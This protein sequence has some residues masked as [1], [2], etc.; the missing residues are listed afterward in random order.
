[1]NIKIPKRRCV[2][3]YKSY[4]K[5]SL[6]R[7]VKSPDGTVFYDEKGSHDGRGAYIC[8]NGQCLARV[9][10]TGALGRTLKCEIPEEIFELLERQAKENE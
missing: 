9:R 4:D 2:G 10:K 1:M 5:S 3:C 7:I 6:F 8:K